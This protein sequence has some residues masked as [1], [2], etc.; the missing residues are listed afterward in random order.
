MER[1]NRILTHSRY[2]ECYDRIQSLETDRKFCGHTIEH[3]LDV[4]RLAYILVLEEGVEIDKEVVYAAGLLHDIGRHLQYDQGIPHQQAGA[5]IAGG[6][7]PEC[8]YTKEE[9]Q[10]IIEAI[11]GHRSV[12]KPGEFGEILYRGDKL[13]RNCFSC[14]VRGECNWT[15]EKQNMEIQY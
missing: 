15:Q 8:G 12:Q 9:E 11:R 2:Q 3:F 4:A 14:R 10:I 1:V 13:S 5:E 6:I 7:L